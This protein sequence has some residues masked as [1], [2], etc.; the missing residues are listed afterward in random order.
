MR[1]LMLCAALTVLSVAPG[2]S[3]Q[4][5]EFNVGAL[6]AAGTEALSA[7]ECKDD[8]SSL[9]CAESGR[10]AIK[11]LC[12]TMDKQAKTDLIR[13]WGTIPFERKR[14]C[15]I[16]SLSNPFLSYSAIKHCIEGDVRPEPVLDGPEYDVEYWYD[17]SRTM[18]PLRNME[19]CQQ[20]RMHAGNVGVCTVRVQGCLTPVESAC[21]KG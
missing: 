3:Q 21:I 7:E 2:V 5:P 10:R 9:F 20:I 13:E 12:S 6:C 19:D 18:I 15:I 1:D 4:L 16:Y 11:S 17:D 8:T 14:T